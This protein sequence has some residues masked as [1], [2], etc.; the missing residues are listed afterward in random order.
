MEKSLAVASE[1]GVPVLRV[2]AGWPEHDRKKQWEEM[3]RCMKISCMLAEREGIVLAVEN[4]NHG[5]FLQTSTDVRRLMNDVDSEWLRLNL[6][7]GN[8]IDGFESIEKTLI[9]TVHAHAKMMDIGADGT[10]TTT[11]YPAFMS[12][13]R[14]ANYRGFLSLE[15]EGAEDSMSAVPRGLEYL[16]RL[17]R[18]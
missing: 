11:D 1:L 18:V 14:D 16:R 7:T 2:F 4:H 15:Y 6:D 9:Y 17:A 12:L 5:G 10:D 13:L 8:Y 3:V